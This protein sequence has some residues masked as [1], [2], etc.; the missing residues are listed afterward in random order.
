MFSTVS[1][2]EIVILAAF[3]L[4]NANAFILALA[5]I[6]AFGKELNPW[7]YIQ[8]LTH[9]HTIPHFDTLN[10]FPNDKF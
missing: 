8:I 2:L 4:L 3:D 7:L 6:L 9:Y 1:K 5:K 10:P